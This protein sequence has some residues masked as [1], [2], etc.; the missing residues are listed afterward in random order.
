MQGPENAQVL[1]SS[2]MGKTK[3]RQQPEWM[4]KIPHLWQQPEWMGKIPHRWQQPEW[5]GKVPNLWQQPEWIGKMLHPKRQ[6]SAQFWYIFFAGSCVI[7]LS[8]D[9]F[10][11]YIPVINEVGKCVDFDR[12]LYI[13][14]VCLRT[15]LDC[16]SLVDIILPFLRSSLDK[17][18]E[19]K[20]DTSHVSLRRKRYLKVANDIVAIL[21]IPQVLFLILFSKNM[22]AFKSLNKRKVLSAVVLLQYLPR[23]LRVYLSWKKVFIHRNIMI[24][25]LSKTVIA[26]KAGFNLFLFII[27]S[28]QP[29]I[30]RS[31]ILEYSKEHFN[32]VQWHPWIFH[33]RPCFWWGLRNLSSFGSNLQTSP[34]FW[35][36]GFA[37]L[38]SISGLVL[39][40]CFLG[41]LQMYTQWEASM[42]LE[43][44][45]QMKLEVAK[46]L[47]CSRWQHYE[48]KDK[49]LKILEWIDRN[50]RLKEIKQQIIDEVDRLFA[51]YKD[52]DVENPFPH[53]PMFIRRK[54][55]HHLCLPLLQKVPLL[56]NESEDALKLI[57]CDFLKQVSYDANSYIVREGEPLDALLFI[58]RG[59]IWTYT[60]GHDHRQT[61]CLKT[62]DIYGVELLEWV[63]KSPSLPDPSNLPFSTR[64]LRCHTKVEAFALTVGNIQH[65][66]YQHWSKFSKFRGTTDSN[67]VQSFVV[68]NVQVAFPRRRNTRQMILGESEQKA[69]KTASDVDNTT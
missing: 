7:S 8:V 49:K 15:L 18:K 11:F 16:V 42:Q 22:R 10:F 32:L 47:E 62:D 57:S 67:L 46:N 17:E 5:V 14:I 25:D 69:R 36:N 21:P 40:V 20:G 60:T 66:L 28:H 68:S 24:I 38:T 43:V 6:P 63:F 2:E 23:A 53:L 65:M 37:V 3:K 26:V 58:T 13:A 48:L 19:T 51:E 56:Q 59:I 29:Q 9:P 39:F 64:T 12:T 30:Q 50:P 31:L 4:G 61:G 54:I 1:D 41:H 52:I 27:A 34:H 45:K 44:A 35:E 33:E 55:Q